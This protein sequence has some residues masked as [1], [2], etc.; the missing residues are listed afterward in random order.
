MVRTTS[1]KRTDAARVIRTQRITRWE[2]AARNRS[3]RVPASRCGG[4]LRRRSSAEVTSSAPPGHQMPSHSQ[5]THR[6][7]SEVNL[8]RSMSDRGAIRPARRVRSKNAPQALPAAE[9]PIRHGRANHPVAQLIG[10]RRSDHPSRSGDRKSIAGGAFFRASGRGA[11][12][13]YAS[14]QIDP[15]TKYLGS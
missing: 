6:R 1:A 11:A 10:H 13:R 7:A 4:V 2:V 9:A 15:L 12:G 8:C 5:G 3:V 14:A